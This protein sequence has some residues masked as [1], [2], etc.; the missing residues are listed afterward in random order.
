MTYEQLV[1]LYE[2]DIGVTLE[3]DQLDVLIPWMKT[4]Y[5]EGVTEDEFIDFMEF[6]EVIPWIQ[7]D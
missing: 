5:G 7:A 3:K 2:S 4:R 1:N 6:L